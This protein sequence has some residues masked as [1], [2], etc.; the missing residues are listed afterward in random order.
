MLCMVSPS[1]CAVRQWMCFGACCSPSSSSTKQVS[2]RC[3]FSLGGGREGAHRGLEVVL[4]TPGRAGT[5]LACVG[6]AVPSAGAAL[7][8]WSSSQGCWANQGERHPVLASCSH[9]VR[10]LLMRE[11]IRSQLQP[12]LCPAA[13]RCA[14]ATKFTVL[15]LVQ[16]LSPPCRL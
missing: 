15:L 8:E 7:R 3:S 10:L 14:S 4:G 6:P 12:S 1:P 16:G 13:A 5:G 2:T 9:V 11:C